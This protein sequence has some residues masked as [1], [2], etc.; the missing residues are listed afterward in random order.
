MWQERNNA[1]RVQCIPCPGA[2]FRGA[3]SLVASVMKFCVNVPFKAPGLVY[4]V[5]TGAIRYG[6]LALSLSLP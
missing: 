2:L 6:D 5:M 3:R 4:N 1:V